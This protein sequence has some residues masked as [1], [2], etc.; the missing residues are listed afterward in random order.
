MAEKFSGVI[1]T[2]VPDSPHKIFIGGLPNYLNE[3]Q[4]SGIDAGLRGGLGWFSRDY[5]LRNSR[6]TPERLHAGM[7]EAHKQQSAE[8]DCVSVFFFQGSSV[9]SFFYLQQLRTNCAFFSTLILPKESF[10][11]T[12]FVEGDNVNEGFVRRIIFI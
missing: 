2:V 8:L 1:S 6:Q 12:C 11:Y 9:I 4:V 5:S 10:F 3:D 7:K